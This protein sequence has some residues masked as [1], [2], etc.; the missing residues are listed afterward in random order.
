MAK[1]KNKQAAGRV[2]NKGTKDMKP[3]DWDQV[4]KLCIMQSTNTEIASF[5][6]MTSE[7]LNNICKKMFKCTASEK[8]ATWREGGN[9]SLRRKQWLLAD[10]NASVCIFLGKQ[11][12][13][14][15]DDSRFNNSGDVR[16]HVMNFAESPAVQWSGETLDVTPKID[17]K[18]EVVVVV[19]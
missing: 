9:I 5:F 1:I 8:M 13:G 16:F 10:T 14:Q 2:K 15:V 6:D 12:L 19:Q 3:I 18:E 4:K 17:D 11:Y 7:T